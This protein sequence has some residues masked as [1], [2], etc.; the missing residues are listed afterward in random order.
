MVPSK[1][2]NFAIVSDAS[3]LALAGFSSKSFVYAG[4]NAAE[5]APSPK[6]LRAKLGNRKAKKKTEE[7]APAPKQRLI[8]ASRPRPAIL[9]SSVIDQTVRVFFSRLSF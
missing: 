6:S 8:A 7:V 1:M 3:A 5:S 9:L 4:T 2:S